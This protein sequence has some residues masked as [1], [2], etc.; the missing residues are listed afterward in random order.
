[1]AFVNVPFATLRAEKQPTSNQLKIKWKMHSI[2][3]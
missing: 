2:S 1:M 3:F